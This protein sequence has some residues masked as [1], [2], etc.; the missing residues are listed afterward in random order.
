MEADA[1]A[2]PQQ[3]SELDAGMPPAD[4]GA[5]TI[6][7]GVE[8]LDATLEMPADAT[9]MPI[10]STLI[11]VLVNPTWPRRWAG[12]RWLKAAVHRHQADT[13]EQPAARCRWLDNRLGWLE[14]KYRRSPGRAQR[15]VCHGR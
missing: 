3:G 6:D 7:A 12:P 10:P 1:E 9:L 4:S 15:R 11:R 8:Q 13:W 2:I 5:P 14:P